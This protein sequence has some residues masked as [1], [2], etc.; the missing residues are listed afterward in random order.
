LRERRED[1]P[2]LVDH[3]VK[4]FHPTQATAIAKG[5]RKNVLLTRL[6]QGFGVDDVKDE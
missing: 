6:I 3:F 5:I 2:L 1:V 4:H